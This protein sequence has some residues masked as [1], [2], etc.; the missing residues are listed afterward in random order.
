MRRIKST[1]HGC[2]SKSSGFVEAGCNSVDDH[3]TVSDDWHAEAIDTIVAD[4]P[5]A[6][7]NAIRHQYLDE[8]YRYQIVFYSANLASGRQMIQW[9]MN[10]KGIW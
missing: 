9:A 1:S 4:L 10:K 6:E 2:P 7:N 5:D 3:E 8:R